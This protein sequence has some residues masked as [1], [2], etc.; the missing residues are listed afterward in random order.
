MI[1]H[2]RQLFITFLIFHLAP[3]ANSC[4]PLPQFLNYN[5]FHLLQYAECR[6]A[7][8]YEIQGIQDMDQCTQACRQFGCAAINFFQLGEFEFMCEILGTVIGVIPAQ[9]AACYTATF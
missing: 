5:N 3:T 1:N 2:Y 6:G 4:S 8:V 7:K 9:G